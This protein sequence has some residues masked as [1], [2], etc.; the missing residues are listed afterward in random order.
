MR[1][2]KDMRRAIEMRREMRKVQ[3]VY[4]RNMC[5]QTVFEFLKCVRMISVKFFHAR[6][7]FELPSKTLEGR[8]AGPGF[9][10]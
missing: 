7:V 4:C 6:S 3:I 1:R 8:S 5:G 9:R 10:F 2:K